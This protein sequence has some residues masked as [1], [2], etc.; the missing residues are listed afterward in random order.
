MPRLSRAAKTL[1]KQVDADYKTDDLDGFGVYRTVI[2][3]K[4]KKAKQIAEIISLDP[5][6]TAEVKGNT[7]T[8]KFVSTIEA[9]ISTP[10]LGLDDPPAVADE[11][12]DD[13]EA[14]ENEAE[15]ADEG[16]GADEPAEVTE[17]A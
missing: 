15:S 7:V 12:A 2:F 14:D 6:T 8:V 17:E 10:F 9:D 3:T 4:V 11:A 13:D 5:R 16:A 1:V